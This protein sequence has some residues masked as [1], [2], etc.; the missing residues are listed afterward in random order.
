V[1]YNGSTYV[2][3]VTNR[4]ENTPDINPKWSLMAQAGA[5]GAS[6]PAG[7]Q[8]PPSPQEVPGIPEPVGPQGPQG[9]GGGLKE[10]KAAL[11]Q[12]YRQDFAT[13]RSPSGIAFDGANVWVINIGDNTVSKL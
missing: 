8:G 5:A 9:S 10:Q 1:T 2:A 3:T 4:G 7:P 12:W 6:G 13:G 11:L